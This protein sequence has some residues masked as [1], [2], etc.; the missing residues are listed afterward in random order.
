MQSVIICDIA[1]AMKYLFLK[2]YLEINQF[3]ISVNSF[4]PLLHFMQV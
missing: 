3:M 4:S 1:F 2:K